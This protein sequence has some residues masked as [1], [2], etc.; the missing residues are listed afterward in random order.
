MK[1]LRS[2]LCWIL[3]SAALVVL[4]GCA[5][6][7]KAVIGLITEVDNTVAASIDAQ[8]DAVET[9]YEEMATVETT[10]LFNAAFFQ[11]FFIG[12]FDPGFDDFADGEGVVWE[13]TGSGNDGDVYFTTERALLQRNDEGSWWY[14]AYRTEEQSLEYE[15][16]LDSSYAPAEIV[17]MDEESDEIVRQKLDFDESDEEATSGQEASAAYSDELYDSYKRGQEQV[18]VGA[19]S[20]T[21]ERIEWDIVDDETGNGLVYS[22]W[23]DSNVPGNLVRYEY[24]QKTGDETSVITGE[25]LSIGRDYKTKFGAY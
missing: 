3:L 25:L 22:W 18:T 11:A 23:V 21:T 6:T 4:G 8:R 19:G 1:L 5:S 7:I 24:R 9:A 12:G 15:M 20:F 17:W 10:L 13:I 2:I 14:I 16:L